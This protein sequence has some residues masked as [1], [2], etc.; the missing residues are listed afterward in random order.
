MTSAASSRFVSLHRPVIAATTVLAFALGGCASNPTSGPLPAAQ[1]PALPG[2]SANA[3]AAGKKRRIPV[4]FNIK[5][6]SK[7]PIRRPHYLPATARSISI[8][9]DAG[10][11]QFVNS[12]KTFV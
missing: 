6:K 10:V 1:A 12:P 5:W 11:P 2:A 4:V 9:L 3:R 8:S 7:H